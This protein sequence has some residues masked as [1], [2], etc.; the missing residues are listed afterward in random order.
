MKLI[1]IGKKNPKKVE[2]LG[3]K[4][5]FIPNKETA[6][7]DKIGIVLLKNAGDVFKNTKETKEIPK[8]EPKAKAKAEAKDK[9]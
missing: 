4:V 2:V 9:K 7:S 3:E 5:S 6:V 8:E 1:Y